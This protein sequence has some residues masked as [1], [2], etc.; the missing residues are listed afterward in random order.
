M[1][2]LKLVAMATT[3]EPSERGWNRQAPIKYLPCGE[4]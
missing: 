1:F 3:L 2:T 4:N